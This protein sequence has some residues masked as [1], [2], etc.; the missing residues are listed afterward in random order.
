MKCL[1]SGDQLVK[2]T[3][4]Y[5]VTTH[6]GNRVEVE[7]VVVYVNPVTKDRFFTDESL[8]LIDGI[9]FSPFKGKVNASNVVWASRVEHYRKMFGLTQTAMAK[10]MGY[11]N[12]SPV[13]HLEN[14]QKRGDRTPTLTKFH[15]VAMFFE[16]LSREQSKG[17]Q[18][19]RLKVTDLF[20]ICDI[21]ES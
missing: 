19:L 12:N 2:K 17:K 14:L 7:G 4:K 6:E 15:E 13:A 3:I 18:V 20:Y 1:F 16:T 10:M 9:R 8:D 5:P 11:K 21:N